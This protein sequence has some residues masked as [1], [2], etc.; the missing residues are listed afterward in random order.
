MQVDGRP[1]V[2]VQHGF[3]GKHE[4]SFDESGA[5]MGIDEADWTG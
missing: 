2:L 1:T 4:L 3:H 5:N